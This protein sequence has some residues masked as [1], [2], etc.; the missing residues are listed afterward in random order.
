MLRQLLN[1]LIL[2]AKQIVQFLINLLL[3]LSI[4][5]NLALKGGSVFFAE[6][7]VLKCGVILL[8]WVCHRSIECEVEPGHL[9]FQLHVLLLEALN[10]LEVAVAGLPEPTLAAALDAI[11]EAYAVVG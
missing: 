9:A 10:L 7:I 8:I 1:R 11:R 6:I 2:G 3:F 4:K 5:W